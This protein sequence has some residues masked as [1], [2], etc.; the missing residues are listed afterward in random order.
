MKKCLKCSTSYCSSLLQCQNCSWSPH[1]VNDF[2]VYAP[3]LSD[4]NSG[5]NPEHFA[6]LAKL[7]ASNFWFRTRNKLILQAISQYAADFESFLEIG[8]GTG[9]VLSGISAHYPNR[10]FTGGEI[11]TEG[12]SFAAARQQIPMKFIQL[13]AR[14]IPFINEFDCI[15]AFDVLEHIDE[16]T[17]VL[18]QIHQSLKKDGILI[19]TVPQHQWLWN[20]IDKIACHVRR[21]GKKDLHQ[22]V[23]NAGYKILCSTSFVTT[24]LPFMLLSRLLKS[25]RSYHKNVY[26]E[27]SLP[28]W[29]NVFFEKIL[30]TE[31]HLIKRGINFP[32]GGSR[33]LLAKKI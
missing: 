20:E 14:K 5:Y 9:Y 25:K 11:Y 31:F 7:E 8:C 27:L 33:L 28:P 17:E 15:G 19:V 4:S 13:D 10:Q 30:N 26:A 3:E 2:P 6:Q 12:L 23:E 24:L 21:Y 32:I 29:L 22:K 16:D 18:K 1:F